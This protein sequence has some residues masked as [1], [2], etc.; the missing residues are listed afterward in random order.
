M[1]SRNSKAKKEKKEKKKLF[2]IAIWKIVNSKTG[3]QADWLQ[4][5][6]KCIFSYYT[7][8]YKQVQKQVGKKLPVQ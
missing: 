7:G 2:W 8:R 3:C 6:K 5:L 1:L 4:S